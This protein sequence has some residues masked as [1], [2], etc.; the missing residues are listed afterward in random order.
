MG[1]SLR[2]GLPYLAGSKRCYT[3]AIQ[4][5]KDILL[6]LCTLNTKKNCMKWTIKKTGETYA[7][8][9]DLLGCISWVG[10]IKLCQRRAKR[11][12][13]GGHRGQVGRVGG[14]GPRLKYIQINIFLDSLLCQA[15]CC[16]YFP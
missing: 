3:K 4:K 2:Y 12:W 5:Q 1:S 7:T 14:E 15:S 16:H 6:K 8:A 10:H 11:S 13:E 9:G